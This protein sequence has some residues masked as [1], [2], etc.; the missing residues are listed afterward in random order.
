MRIHPDIAGIHHITAVASS[1][2]DNLIFYEKILGLLTSRWPSAPTQIDE[3]H[4]HAASLQPID[5]PQI[6]AT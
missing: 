1:A 2:A 6:I 3:N 4:L 5:D